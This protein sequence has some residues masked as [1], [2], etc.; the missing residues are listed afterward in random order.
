MPAARLSIDQE[1]R[2]KK[3]RERGRERDFAK[4]FGACFRTSESPG[5][6][7]ASCPP[8]LPSLTVTRSHPANTSSVEE[9]PAPGLPSPKRLA[10]RAAERFD[11]DRIPEASRRL[12]D[13]AARPLSYSLSP[14]RRHTLYF[15]IFHA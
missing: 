11:P 4:L 6:P 12:P 15:F 10:R 3:E 5:L 1:E 8:C 7:A 13:G 9:R 14:P 2:E